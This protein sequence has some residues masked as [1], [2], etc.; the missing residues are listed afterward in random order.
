M[1]EMLGCG[2]MEYIVFGASTLGKTFSIINHA[3]PIAYFCDNDMEKWGMQFCEKEVIS[4]KELLKIYDPEKYTIVISSMYAPA[5]RT[6]LMKMGIEN[7]VIFKTEMRSGF[8]DEEREIWSFTQKYTS[9]SGIFCWDGVPFENAESLCYQREVT[10]LVPTYKRVANIM[11]CIKYFGSINSEDL[12][13]RLLILDASPKKLQD[14][15]SDFIKDI[16]QNRVCLSCFPDGYNFWERLIQGIQQ[17]ETEYFAICGDDDFFFSDGLLQ[18]V[19]LLDK[20]KDYLAARGR[21]YQFANNRMIDFEYS[22]IIPHKKS[23][24]A[25][26]LSGR[27][28]EWKDFGGSLLHIVYRT[29]ELRTISTVWKENLSLIMKMNNHFVEWFF[30][31]ILLSWGKIGAVQNKFHLRNLTGQDVNVQRP[32]VYDALL[33][34]RFQDNVELSWELYHAFFPHARKQEFL[35]WLQDY[36]FQVFYLEGTVK[37]KGLSTDI[38]KRAWENSSFWIDIVKS[39]K[40]HGGWIEVRHDTSN[41]TGRWTN[42]RGGNA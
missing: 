2:K 29:S 7:F 27:I 10:I 21:V 19:M 33:A 41:A 4:P 40:K 16:P 35:V 38:V 12:G 13:I 1:L 30:Y 36:L 28:S 23:I 9:E 39:R 37:E 18:C 8:S 14:E 11:Q 17:V 31:L 34:G 22:S 32:M 25:D 15:I 6:Q 5:I 20:N 26:S 42:D 3:F 24:S